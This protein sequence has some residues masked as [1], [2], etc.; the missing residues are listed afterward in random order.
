MESNWRWNVSEFGWWG[1][2]MEL[3]ARV[4]P[5][6]LGWVLIKGYPS[7]IRACLGQFVGPGQLPTILADFIW[8]PNERFPYGLDVA[9][10]N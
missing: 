2:D 9:P 1:T 4:Y 5:L 6:E 10:D 3:V 7:P 8:A